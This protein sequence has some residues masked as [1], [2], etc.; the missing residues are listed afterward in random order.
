MGKT[1]KQLQPGTE[2]QILNAARRVFTRKGFAAARMEDIAQEAG[3]NRALLH[4]YFRSKD[5]MFDM[6]F[7]ENMGKFFQDLLLHFRVKNPLKKNQTIDFRG[8]RY[9]HSKSG[10]ATIY[11]K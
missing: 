9:T 7:K 4:Y 10:L 1:T 8:I 11:R 6:V 3:I 2:E 5:K